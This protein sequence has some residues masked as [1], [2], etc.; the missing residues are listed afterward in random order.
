MSEKCYTGPI[1][2]VIFDG[3]FRA[4]CRIVGRVG[5]AVQVNF[6]EWVV[7][8][9]VQTTEQVKRLCDALGREYR[10]PTLF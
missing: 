4:E 6:G 7:L 8:R 5:F 1:G 3:D 2:T 9:D 10:D